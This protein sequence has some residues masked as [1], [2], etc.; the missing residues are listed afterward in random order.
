MHIDQKIYIS[1][2][3]LHEFLR[4]VVRGCQVRGRLCD[5]R[6][7]DIPRH[8]HGMITRTPVIRKIHLSLHPRAVLNSL[9]SCLKD[10]VNLFG[11]LYLPKFRRCHIQLLQGRGRCP[12]LLLLE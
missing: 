3:L 12:L 7:A 5:M 2:T 6:R 1:R 11:V 9:I 4:R 8:V 10:L